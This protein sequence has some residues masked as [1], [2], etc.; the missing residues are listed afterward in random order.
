MI[1]GG[2][3]LT[4]PTPPGSPLGTLDGYLEGWTHRFDAGAGGDL[5][6]FIELAVSDRALTE[7]HT[8]WDT[9]APLTW[10]TAIPADTW[11]TP[12]LTGASA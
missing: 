2:S 3:P 7:V 10:D 5:E 8:L 9:S 6:W 12:R 11:N 1:A 4:V